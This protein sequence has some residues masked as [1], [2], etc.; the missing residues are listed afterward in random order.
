MEK[1]IAKNIRL[2]VFVIL[3]AILLIVGL[4]I[5]GNKQNLFGRTF[6]VSAKFYNVNGLM[7]GNNVRFAGIDVGTVK[8]VEIISDSSVNVIMI[9]KRD[10]QKFIKKNALVSIGT[11]GLMGNKLVNIAIIDDSAPGI[12]DG[13]E[14]Q[15]IRPIETDEM[16]RTLN[17]TNE[18]IKVISS[19]LRNITDKISS[20][21]SFWTI[22]MDTVVAENIKTAILNIKNVGER[23]AILAG[24]L[25][26]FSGKMNTGKGTL[27]SLVNDTSLF[28]D[29]SRVVQNLQK[30]SD[31]AGIVAKDISS[32]VGKIKKGEG[33]VG[34]LLTD[35]TF[36]HNLNQSVQSI[37][38]AAKNFDENMEALK[39][40]ILLRK[41]YKK[42][43]KKAD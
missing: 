12:E 39:S 1:E 21:N 28:G 2:G 15:T 5:V 32:I 30:I 11:D 37:N 6:T 17:A 33:S 38:E 29:F 40:N 18:N 8:R 23:S 41:Y 36:S 24:N 9:I 14:L 22:L 13:D 26:K 10:V 27:S 7:K 20:E 42:Q 4:Y 31:T 35:T 3:G 43:E 25:E 19:N 16:T 34:N